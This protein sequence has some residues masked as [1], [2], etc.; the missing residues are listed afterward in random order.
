MWYATVFLGSIPI[1]LHRLAVLTIAHLLILGAFFLNAPPVVPQITTSTRTFG[2]L[3]AI[4][5][6]APNEPPRI[7]A[8]PLMTP[9]E[10]EGEDQFRRMPREEFRARVKAILAANPPPR[11]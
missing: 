11:R 4:S 3:S 2:E 7:C 10:R 6:L 1:P 8:L 9:E 5:I